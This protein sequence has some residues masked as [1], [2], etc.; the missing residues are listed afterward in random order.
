MHFGLEPQARKSYERSLYPQKSL[1]PN[2]KCSRSAQERKDMSIFQKGKDS[3]SLKIFTKDV[4]V[5]TDGTREKK[6]T[7][8]K[9]MVIHVRDFTY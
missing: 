7:G 8:S 4:Q 3:D 5:V 2:E 9:N 6:M 1:Q